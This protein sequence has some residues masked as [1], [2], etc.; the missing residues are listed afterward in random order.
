MFVIIGQNALY[1]EVY[2]AILLIHHENE[3]FNLISL[4]VKI[5]YNQVPPSRKQL[6]NETRY[7]IESSPFT[8]NFRMIKDSFHTYLLPTVAN[9]LQEESTPAPWLNPS[10][11]ALDEGIWN[12]TKVH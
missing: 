10:F 12:V 11:N 8:M 4:M 9:W 7:S 5:V 2:F 1:P 6:N 3:A